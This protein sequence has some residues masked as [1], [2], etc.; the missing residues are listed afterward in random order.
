MVGPLLSWYPSIS[1]HP[2]LKYQP[3]LG[4]LADTMLTLWFSLTLAL[5]Q[6]AIATPLPEETEA[7]RKLF[8]R[9][10]ISGPKIGGA[11]FPGIYIKTV[12]ANHS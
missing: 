6:N 9:D 7:K 8:K 3:L 12:V 2:P 1:I 11:N 4:M 10:S 5:V